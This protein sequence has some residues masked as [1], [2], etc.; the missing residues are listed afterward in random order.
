MEPRR[1]RV[2]TN[3]A[4]DRRDLGAGGR[5]DQA[6]DRDRLSGDRDREAAARDERAEDRDSIASGQADGH[7]DRAQ[8]IYRRLAD[9]EPPRASADLDPVE[10]SDLDP[11]LT[12]RL[13]VSEAEQ[14]RL[15]ALDRAAISDLLDSLG[16]DLRAGRGERL[17]AAADRAAGAADRAAATQDREQAEQD[18]FA[19][20]QDR[21]QAAIERGQRA[22]HD[23]DGGP[24]DRPPV[25]FSLAERVAASVT[26][27]RRRIAA[28]QAVLRRLGRPPD[29]PDR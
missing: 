26:A 1:P 18:R 14:R 29:M 23:P 15:A 3:T 4:A 16:D 13:R 5:D 22:G 7:D 19:A 6:D 17:A 12:A 11:V 8:Q 20:A 21:D 24:P 9:R 10:W 2:D 27:S 28:S 25:W